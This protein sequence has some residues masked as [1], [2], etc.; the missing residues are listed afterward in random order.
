VPT[1]GI[2]ADV[3]VEGAPL[4]VLV[5]GGTGTVP[6]FVEDVVDVVVD[7]GTMFADGI[8][9]P[10]IG[11]VTTPLP[12]VVVGTELPDASVPEEP[13]VPSKNS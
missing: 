5:V 11:G 10:G 3:V 4:L 2:V 8:V 1:V 7:E 9:P 12:V 13:V 6:L